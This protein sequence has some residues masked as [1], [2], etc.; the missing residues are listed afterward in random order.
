MFGYNFEL[1]AEFSLLNVDEWPFGVYT[2]IIG[3][4]LVLPCGLFSSIV[5][6]FF[7]SEGVLTR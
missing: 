2:L 5:A 6:S 1:P 3:V 7:D 4:L